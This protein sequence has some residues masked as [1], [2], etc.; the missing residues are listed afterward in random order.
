M[1]AALVVAALMAQ[2]EGLAATAALLVVPVVEAARVA[3]QVPA[4]VKAATVHPVLK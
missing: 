4:P 3:V 2:E 1:R